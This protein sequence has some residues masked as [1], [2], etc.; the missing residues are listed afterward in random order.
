MS[1]PV[2]S[3]PLSSVAS[4]GS[5]SAWTTKDIDTTS[6]DN[7][8]ASPKSA[9][10]NASRKRSHAEAN[11]AQNTTTETKPKRVKKSDQPPPTG[12]RSSGR[13]RKAPA[14]FG[15]SCEA[16]KKS[17]VPPPKRRSKIFEPSFLLTNSMSRLGK[18][19]IF[20]ML[21]DPQKGA[22]ICLTNDQKLKILALLPK[23]RANVQLAAD[24][25]SGTAA[26]DDIPKELKINHTVF[27]AD[28]AKF[29]EDL[30]SGCLTASWLAAAERAVIARAAGEYDEWKAQEIEDW[31]GQ[32]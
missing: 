20:H 1:P 31:W 32:N 21:V 12:T 3:S 25:A 10:S 23:S 24:L 4:P 22:W 14:R 2:A 29:Q 8:I 9:D 26:I 16:P 7:P 19:D 18:T 28:V 27:R 11:G 15:D 6:I 17:V 30:T 5:P 13:I